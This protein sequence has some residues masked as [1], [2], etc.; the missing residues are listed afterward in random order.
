MPKKHSKP[1]ADLKK[2][3]K[4]LINWDKFKPDRFKYWS[5]SQLNY[6]TYLMVLDCDFIIVG[7][8]IEEHAELV[9][10][11]VNPDAA[12]DNSIGALGFVFPMDVLHK[13]Y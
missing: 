12:K 6:Y 8:G 11:R 9:K 5:F 7:I 10:A 1:G 3:D 4:V 2:G 13:I